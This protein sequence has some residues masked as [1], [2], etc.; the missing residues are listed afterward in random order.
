[1]EGRGIG[2]KEL[3]GPATL[4]P[5]WLQDAVMPVLSE[6]W[7]RVPFLAS[8]HKD[9]TEESGHGFTTLGRQ[10]RSFVALDAMGKAVLLSIELVNV[11][12]A[13]S[14]RRPSSAR[15]MTPVSAMTST[16]SSRDRIFT[17]RSAF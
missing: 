10:K 17:A 4:D 12:G 2:I 11:V 16:A 7:Q 9:L 8:E 14:E 5:E 1:M 3:A 6:T 15:P 13:T